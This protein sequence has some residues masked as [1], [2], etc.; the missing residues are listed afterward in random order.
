MEKFD[1][2]RL[3]NDIEITRTLHKLMNE[4]L[5]RN[6]IAIEIKKILNEFDQNCSALTY[7]KGIYIYGSPGCGKTHFITKRPCPSVLLHM[8]KCG[9]SDF[10]N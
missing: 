10:N 7:K 4:I 5:D 8:T 3:D 6:S 9:C 1:L 2:M